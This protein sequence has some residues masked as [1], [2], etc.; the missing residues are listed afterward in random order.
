MEKKKTN[1]K[2]KSST[3]KAPHKLVMLVVIVARK[4]SDFFIDILEENE[5]NVTFTTFGR[6]TSI[7]YSPSDLGN[8]ERGKAVIFGVI[9]QDKVKSMLSILSEKF[10][11]VRGGKGV[12]FTVDLASVIGVS[13]YKFLANIER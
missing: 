4:K 1:V 12:A 9:R 6:G 2:K 10:E 5:V 8:L 13:S 7:K 3:P 11:K